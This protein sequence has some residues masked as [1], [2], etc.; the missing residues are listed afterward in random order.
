M[1]VQAVDSLSSSEPSSQLRRIKA[2][3]TDLHAAVTP[4]LPPHHPVL[5]T[6][7]SQLSPTPSPLRSATIHVREVASA[8]RE[9]C[10]PARDPA[11][12]CIMQAL[13]NP[14][15]DVSRAGLIVDAVKS[16]LEI[17]EVMK[18]DLSQ[19][20]MGA[21]SEKQLRGVIRQEAKAKERALV[22]QLWS[23]EEVR[24][25]WSEWL[26]ELSQP[27]GDAVVSKWILGLFQA[28]TST[29]PVSSKL[30]TSLSIVGK[31]VAHAVPSPMQE[32]ALPPLFLHS[33]PSLLYLQDYLQALVI[34]ASLRSLT[35]L[36]QPS[37]RNLAPQ[38]TTARPGPAA[39]FMDRVWALLRAELDEEEGADTRLTNLADEVVRARMLATGAPGLDADGEAR[40]RAAVER[41][42]QPTDPVYVLLQKR[43]V[44]A[45]CARLTDQ[46]ERRTNVLAPAKMQTGRDGERAQKRPRLIIQ[47]EEVDLDDTE[48]AQP[49]PPLTVKGFEDPVLVKSVTEALKRLRTD[50]QWISSVWEDVVCGEEN[51]YE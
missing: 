36:T 15:P 18:S 26:G 19:F 23:L 11:L 39:D 45:L 50:V 9:R 49:E 31:E 2:L 40:L 20:I 6:L 47:S 51:A 48:H 17:A 21:M 28:L 12:D 30:P 38:T 43:L 16:I 13:D 22:L 35:F 7:A 8:L 25:L 44:A 32:N 37:H 42:L 5:V 10:A 27:L 33:I 34:A 3:Y 41:T 46:Q 29:H 24:R 4:L 1:L 14:P